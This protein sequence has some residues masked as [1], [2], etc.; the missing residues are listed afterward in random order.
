MSAKVWQHISRSVDKAEKLDDNT[1]QYLNLT[2][3]F[4]NRNMLPDNETTEW[5]ALLRL[6]NY[7]TYIRSRKLT[8][9]Y[10]EPLHE[11]MRNLSG[12]AKK[13]AQ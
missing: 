1:K 4:S 2:Q 5:R 12:N 9:I 11:D 7:I 10:N 6:S 13:I 8:N 3:V